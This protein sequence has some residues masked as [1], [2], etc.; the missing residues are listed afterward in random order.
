MSTSPAPTAPAP[1]LEIAVYTVRPSEV[2]AFPARQ[3]AIHAALRAVPGFLGAERLRGLDT[4]T[5]FADYVLWASRADAETAAAQLQARPDGAAFMAA[6]AELRTFAHLPVE[7][8]AGSAGA[9]AG[10][11]DGATPTGHTGAA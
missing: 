11:P 4:P 3:A 5:L 6:I 8:S 7:A 1:C 9:P 10:V 2:D